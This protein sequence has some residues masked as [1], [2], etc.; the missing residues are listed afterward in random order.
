MRVA[1]V[2]P[3]PGIGDMIWHLP[4]IRAVAAWLGQPVTLIAKPRSLAAEILAGDPAVGDIMWVDLNPD[5]RRGAHDGI[6]GFFRLTAALRARRFDMMLMLHHSD[7]IAAAAMLA[8]VPDRRGY[9]WGAQRWFLNHGP[10]LPPEVKKLHQHTRATRY[11]AAAGIPLP[12]A[13]PR[14]AVPEPLVAEAQG[15]LAAVPRPF[16][17]IGIGASEPSRQ[18]GA[19]RLADL[20]RALLAAGWPA[21]VL[22]GGPGEQALADEIMVRMGPDAARATP[23]IGWPLLLAGA[24][25]TESAFYVGNNTGVMN[26]AAAVNVRTY[27]LFGTCP[28]FFHASQILPILSPAGGPDDGM[29]RLT[30]AAA[31]DAIR[32]DRGG[33]APV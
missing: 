32:D 26:L 8:G 18:F 21:V 27:A 15:R 7:T 30:V 23:A 19:E 22:L 5:G 2:Q 9:G 12:S 6:G 14:L 17:A 29:A 33:L 28:P 4:H 31:L 24:L 13:E 1:L 11:L 10:Y 20:A 3:L 25:L 16:I